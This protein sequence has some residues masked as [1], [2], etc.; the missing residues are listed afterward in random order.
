MKKTATWLVIFAMSAGCAYAQ[1]QTEEENPYVWKTHVETGLALTQSAYSDNWTGG[2]V[3]SI[4]WAAN[5]HGTAVKQLSSKFRNENDLKLAFGQT[6]SQNQETKVW[7]KPQKS[8]DKIR[9]DTILKLTLQAWVDPYVAGVF[10]SQFYD[11]S[12]PEVKRYINPMTLTESVGASRTLFD[13]ENGKATTRL[14]FGLRQVINRAV[15][16][17]LEGTT[18]T[19]TSYDGGIEWVTDWMALLSETLTYTTKLTV[20]QAL[21]YSEA[22]DLEGT[23]KADYWKA[24]DMAWENLLTARVSKIV[25]VSLAWELLYDKE[26]DKGGR[27]KETLALGVAWVL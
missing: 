4:I 20:F 14:G 25:Q 2:E 16:D 26:I 15:V 27:F 1:E 9:F 6:H 3:G 18:E 10:E 19:E 11:A 7:S 5:L 21:F 23:E 22:E 12:V 24:A 17:T 13:R 8:T